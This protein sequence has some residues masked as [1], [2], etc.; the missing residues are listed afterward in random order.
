MAHMTSCLN[1]EVG[2]GGGGGQKL[3]NR[4]ETEVVRKAPGAQRLDSIYVT[5]YF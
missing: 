5:R 4:E 1:R 3:V 2:G